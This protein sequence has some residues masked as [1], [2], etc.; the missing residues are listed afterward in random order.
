MLNV[1]DFQTVINYFTAIA[2]SHVDINSFQYGDFD[3]MNSKVKSSLM[4][5]VL[6]MHPYQ[7]VRITD[8][9]SDNE[10]GVK[11]ISLYLYAKANSEAFADRDTKYKELEA[12]VRDILG[13]M[14]K[15]WNEGTIQ[16]DI[17]GFQ[18]GEADTTI[19]GAT[20]FV[21]CRLDINF[22]IPMRLEYNEDKW[23]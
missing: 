18:Y 11:Q 6:W 15:D 22:R 1:Y 13:K 8:D 9:R 23:T 17:N 4:L 20:N 7:P 3:V 10:T 19:F 14:K 2:A 21:G 5:P 12:I 16:T